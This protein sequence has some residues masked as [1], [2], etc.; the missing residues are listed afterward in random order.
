MQ[1]S[2]KYKYKLLHYPVNKVH[3]LNAIFLLKGFVYA[4]VQ[5][6]HHPILRNACAHFI[7]YHKTKPAERTF[8]FYTSASCCN[9]LPRFVG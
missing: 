3:G 5:P 7:M 6:Q 2:F 8:F 9:N 4:G 1:G